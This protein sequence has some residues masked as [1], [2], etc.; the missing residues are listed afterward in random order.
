MSTTPTPTGATYFVLG[1]LF[2]TTLGLLGDSV[3]RRMDELG[4]G[5]GG[6][7]EDLIRKYL[8]SD[9][10]ADADALGNANAKPKLWIHI[11]YERNARRWETFQSRCT[12]NLNQPY[13]NLTVETVVGHCGKSFQVCLVDDHSFDRLLGSDWWRQSEGEEEDEHD[14]G[15]GRHDHPILSFQQCPEPRRSQLREVA[16]LELLYRYGGVVVP[17]TFISMADLVDVYE[18]NCVRSGKPF[19]T[20]LPNCWSGGGGGGETHPAS[21]GRPT[22][23]F[24]PS[25]ALMGA[26][27]K[28]ATVRE[29]VT[30]LRRL[31]GR[32]HAD[33]PDFLGVWRNWLR[34]QTGGG[35]GGSLVL[36]DGGRVGTKTRRGKPVLLEDL[37][38]EKYLDLFVDDSS[39]SSSSLLGVYV[40]GEQLLRRTKYQW[41]AVLPREDLFRCN[42]IVAKYLLAA[43]VETH[44]E[45]LKRTPNAGGGGSSGGGASSSASCPI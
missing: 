5:G 3:K 41:F 27:R 6:G 17:C 15:G 8:L 24:S 4:G 11:P 1:F 36:L 9:A 29:M 26:P 12:S 20:E 7:D 32:T 25:T 43:L 37:F 14:G 13:V 2:L 42:A 19:V 28:N 40:P 31:V 30:V 33:R 44:D 39:S 45:Y 23:L 34:V 22:P 18:S 21:S 10:G 16:M 38:E 35:G